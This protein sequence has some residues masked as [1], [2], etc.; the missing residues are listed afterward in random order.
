MSFVF[1]EKHGYMLK[2]ILKYGVDLKILLKKSFDIEVVPKFIHY[3]TI[4]N[5]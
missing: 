2:N 3:N 5:N 4:H 1:D